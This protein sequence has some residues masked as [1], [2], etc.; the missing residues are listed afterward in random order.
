MNNNKK[1]II[2][3]I[4]IILIQVIY[5][6]YIDYNKEDFF[7]DELYSYGLMNYKQAFI[8]EEDTF[9]NN[10]HNKEYFDDYLTVSKDEA[11]D[12]SAVYKNQTEDYHPPFYYL[13]LRIMANFT[14]DSF[15]KWTGLILNIIIFVFCAIIVFLIGKKIFKNSIYAMLLV[16]GYGFS[17]FSTENTLFIRMYQLLELQMLLISYWGINN[18]YKKNLNLKNFICLIMLIV[19]GT[20]TQ[21]YYIIFLL[22]ICI[23]YIIKYIR[24]KQIKNL[25]KFIL[26]LIIAQI[27]ICVIFPKY[28]DQLFSNSIRSSNT[29]IKI[30]KK[31]ENNIDREC[32]YLDILNKNMFGFEIKYLVYLIILLGIIILIINLVRKSKHKFTSNKRISI[33]IVPTIIYWLAITL[34]SPY[35]DLRYILPIFVFILIIIVYLLKKE[36]QIII[37]NQKIVISIISIIILLYTVSFILPTELRYQYKSSKEKIENI[38]QYKNIPCIYMYAHS[39]VLNNTFVMNLNYVRQFENVYIMDKINFTING[40]EK[41]LQGIDISNG[42]IIMENEI[43]AENR[44][45]KIIE[46]SNK[47]SNYKKIE[48]ITIERVIYDEIYLV[49]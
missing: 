28:K 19:L 41:A 49:Y 31:I 21:Y 44:V 4:I 12:F 24:K 47:F 5:K 26:A 33:I 8:F 35:I 1:I 7:V 32:K 10:W 25:G 48:E 27:L 15:T 43:N 42:I 11:K 45:K 38:A 40:L 9:I 16:L 18:Y 46:E 30:I 23:V 37:K 13:L 20:L 36:I 29:E 22:G 6:I 17:K 39:D 3:L 2:I 14:I 34:T